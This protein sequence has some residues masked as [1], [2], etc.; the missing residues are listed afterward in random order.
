MAKKKEFTF[1]FHADSWT[2]ITVKAYNE[3]EA[4]ELADEK[5]NNGD[6]SDEDT[7]FENTYVENITED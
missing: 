1:R 6:Y 3:D 4:Y 7:D 5:Y 2:D